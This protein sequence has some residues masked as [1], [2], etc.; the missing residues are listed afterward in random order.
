MFIVTT[1]I[2]FDGYSLSD[3]SKW[4]LIRINMF[5]YTFTFPG[6]ASGKVS[7]YS[8]GNLLNKEVLGR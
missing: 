4:K 3:S 1:H 2:E 6:S 8:S 5:G 7:A